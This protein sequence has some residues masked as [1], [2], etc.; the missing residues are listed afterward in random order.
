MPFE[1]Q[2]SVMRNPHIKEVEVTMFRTIDLDDPSG[3][4]SIRFRITIYDQFDQPMS[5]LHGDLIPHL[6]STIRQ[7]LLAF[8]DWLWTKAEDE[9]IG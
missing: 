2:E 9:V 8:M 7:Q 6:A 3:L 4:Q 5:H 1:R